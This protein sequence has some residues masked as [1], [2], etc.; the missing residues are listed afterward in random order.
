MRSL[1]VFG[2]AIVLSVSMAFTPVMAPASYAA[3]TD[4]VSYEDFDGKN[5]DQLK[6][7][8]DT[9]AL[10]EDPELYRY[11]DVD[12]KG[13]LQEKE[14]EL[15]EVDQFIQKM[16]A[17]AEGISDKE[18][19]QMSD[20]MTAVGC[21]VSGLGKAQTPSKYKKYKRLNCIDISWWQGDISKTSWKKIKD[22]GVKYV[23]IRTGYTSLSKFTLNMDSKF[24]QNINNA[25]EAG[26]KIG[27][28]HFSQALTVAEAEKE[29]AYTIKLIENYR[30]KITLPVVFDYET[31][32][33]GRLTMKKLKSLYSQGL[34]PKICMAFCDKIKAAGYK[35][36]LYAN[37]TML[38]K[39][40]DYQTLQKKYRIWLANYTTNGTAT[41]YPGEYWMWQYSSSGKVNGLK[42]SVDINYVFRNGQGGS[43]VELAS[44]SS[45]TT[46]T[47]TTDQTQTTQPTTPTAKVLYKAKVISKVNYRTGPGTNYTKKGS[48]KKGKILSVVATKGKWSKLDNGYY[49]SSRWIKKLSTSYKAKTTD[50]VNYRTG[51]GVKYKRVGTYKKGT[52]ITVVGEKNGWVK[53]KDGY[54]LYKGYTKKL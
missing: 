39:Y 45:E 1:L 46:T 49:V 44:S 13:N 50:S 48:Y 24:S 33:R 20:N 7:Q 3:N 2:L 5:V 27:V 26:L 37:Y 14:V 40:L 22:A 34:S 32:A 8:E 25:Y 6:S 54:Y 53:T 18:I 42:G 16:D 31:N 15:D 51:P 30:S 9:E 4:D 11:Y 19:A 23:I 41:T 36:M 21:G 38:S 29:A 43:P 47:T 12:K 28:Y 35:P 52:K 10:A 17:N